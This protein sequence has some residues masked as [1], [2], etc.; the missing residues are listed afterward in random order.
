MRR[1]KVTKV[2]A[3]DGYQLDVT[4]SDGTRGIADLSN[5]LTGPLAPL[6]GA[7]WK[8]A[9]VQH[10]VVVWNDEL[11]LAPEFVYARAHQLDPPKSQ[12]QVDANQMAVTMRELRVIAGK[13]QVE[14]AEE[15]GV[16]QGEISRLEGRSDTKLST[17]ERYVHALGGE[18]EIVARFGDRSMTVRLG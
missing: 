3:L 18:V 6:Q 4:F 9:H 16:A 17:L 5:D 1:I 8:D 11:D 14:V 13:S 15:M 10:G 7:L 2:V 12:E